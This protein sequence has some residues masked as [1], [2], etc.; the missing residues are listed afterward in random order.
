METTKASETLQ[1][2][3]APRYRWTAIHNCTMRLANGSKVITFD[4]VDSGTRWETSATLIVDIDAEI[5]TVKM[6]CGEYISD[7]RGSDMMKD[8]LAGACMRAYTLR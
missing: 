5:N 6:I 3:S 7:H 2:H 1:A 8:T 4:A